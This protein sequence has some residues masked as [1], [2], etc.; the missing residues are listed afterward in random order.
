MDFGPVA[1]Q[2][3]VERRGARGRLARRRLHSFRRAAVGAGMGQRLL[4]ALLAE[5]F[6][7]VIERMAFEGLQ[8]VLVVGRDEDQA[9]LCAY[10]FRHFEAVQARHLDVE[11]H[12][13]RLQFRD[14]LDGLEAVG[15]F[16]HD[17]DIVVA[18]QIFAQHAARQQFI[19]DDGYPHSCL[20]HS[21]SI[22][23]VCAGIDIVT[24][25]VAPRRAQCTPAS[26]P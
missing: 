1:Y 7:Q 3:A 4:E 21:S 11:E 20:H 2:H 9:R 25:N 5:R 19:V 24:S 16:G 13:L 6:Q 17:L 23:P 14:G 26:W 22:S 18:R 15:A 10:Q 12:Q 8:G